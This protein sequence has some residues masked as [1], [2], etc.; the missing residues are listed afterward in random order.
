MDLKKILV[1]MS[2]L[3]IL[4][5]TIWGCLLKIAHSGSTTVAYVQVAHYDVTKTL[6]GHCCTRL[7]LSTE[8]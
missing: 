1:I 6:R 7:G 3:E 5:S 2:N 4:V 8:V